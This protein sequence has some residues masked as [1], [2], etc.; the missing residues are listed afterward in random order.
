MLYHT[1][2]HPAWGV[3]MSYTYIPDSGIEEYVTD[4]LSD[5]GVLETKATETPAGLDDNSSDIPDDEELAISDTGDQPS[6]KKRKR[7]HPGGAC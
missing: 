2:A 6:F 4:F 1:R 3:V 7:T 5:H